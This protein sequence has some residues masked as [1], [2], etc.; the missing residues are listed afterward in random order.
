V[1]GAERYRLE[2]YKLAFSRDAANKPNYIKGVFQ[3]SRFTQEGAM[4]GMNETQ[5][6]RMGELHFSKGMA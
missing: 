1:T 3:I 2:N 6:R 5:V 4:I